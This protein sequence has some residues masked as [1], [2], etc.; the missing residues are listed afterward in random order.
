NE[1]YASEKSLD[2]ELVTRINTGNLELTFT[3]NDLHINDLPLDFTGFIRFPESGYDI[4]LRFK[5][6]QT[7]VR[8]VVTVLPPAY[9]KWL[10]ETEVKGLAS[11]FLDFV[12]SYRAET[13][14]N[15]SLL[16]GL[17]IEDGY[18]RNAQ[19]PVPVSDLGMKFRLGIPAMNY[20]SLRMDLDTLHLKMGQGFLQSHF[21][22]LNLNSPRIKSLLKADADL[23]QLMQ[24]VGYNEI[25]LKGKLVCDAMIDYNSETDFNSKS[26][27]MPVA[28][29]DI[30]WKN[31]FI[32]T[33]Y[34]PAPLKDIDMKV[35]ITNLTGTYHDMDIDLQPIT[36]TFEDQPFMI[37]ADVENFDNVQYDVVS[38][39][40]LDLEKISKVFIPEKYGIQVQGLIETDLKLKGNQSDAIKGLYSRLNNSGTLKLKDIKLKSNELP[41]PVWI[42]S[43]DFHIQDDKLNADNLLLHY[44]SSTIKMKGYYKNLFP[45]MTG[46]GMLKGGLTLQSD[47]LNLNEFLAYAVGD[48]SLSTGQSMPS[49]A[50]AAG[51]VAMLPKNL[52]LTLQAN[53]REAVYDQFV[54]RNIKGELK[55]DGGKLWLKD[56][57]AG[58]A[59][60][61]AILNASYEPVST[62]RA[63]FD[64]DI[65][66]DSFDI[67]R[68]YK[69][70]PLFAEMAPSAKTVK[71]QVSLKYQL[72]GNLDDNM[73]PVMPSLKGG[74]TLSL[75]NVQVKGL[76]LFSA[77]ARKTGRDS[78]GNPN[79][80]AV[81]LNTT[82][83]KNIMTLE[84][85]RM[86][87]FGFRPRIEGQAS[88]DGRLN[89]RFRLGL[90][91]FGIIGIPM[92]ITGTME[93]PKV[94][95][96]K[97]KEEDE[98]EETEDQEDVEQ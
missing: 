50:G 40:I 4:D 2:A 53:I 35:I 86:K 16:F 83:A 13:G 30:A 47:R 7:N 15:P 48:D 76:K 3:K 46:T 65:K 62:N 82:I 67:Q 84:R 17:D 94:N 92:T 52:D 20:D 24:A 59:G 36:F 79:L 74:G 97:G 44:G 25:M 19:T 80:K 64:V 63:V 56:A 28:K 55:L 37:K 96:R 73:M 85:T 81:N 54:M 66:A 70:V 39:G 95:M 90:P 49:E 8:N 45:F 61:K 78:I 14:E 6:E 71:G 21:H 5:S 31:G 26:R 32:Q 9:L 34:Y 22:L 58:L 43:G 72:A 98:L 91:P 75:H 33:P 60:A 41:Y 18:V 87:I 68:F 23:G 88:L 10:D 42:T 93:N 12:G 77:V 69:E 11:L 38:K 1:K 57:G 89:L 27:R 51:G 29:A